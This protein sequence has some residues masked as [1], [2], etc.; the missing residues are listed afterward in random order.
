MSGCRRFRTMTNIGD[1]QLVQALYFDSIVL[2]HVGRSNGDAAH[3][4][5]NRTGL[6]SSLAFA[7]DDIVG[8]Q[9]V[10]DED[11]FVWRVKGCVALDQAARIKLRS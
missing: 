2:F 7:M 3:R 10:H 9:M 1:V 5:S 11:A 8:L 6:F 4:A